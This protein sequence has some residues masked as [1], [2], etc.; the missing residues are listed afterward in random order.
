MLNVGDPTDESGPNI[1]QS[2][3]VGGA[4]RLPSV[5]TAE[6]LEVVSWV[7]QVLEVTA[8]LLVLV[9]GSEELGDELFP[10]V[11]GRGD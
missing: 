7:T 3:S 10:F 1:M 6:V 2:V 4:C 11:T 5:D 9:E 8:K